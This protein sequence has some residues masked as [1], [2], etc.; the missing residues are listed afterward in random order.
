MLPTRVW[1]LADLSSKNEKGAPP[2]RLGST[3][4]THGIHGQA[5]QVP[6]AWL[7]SS[8]ARIS[9]KKIAKA[10]FSWHKNF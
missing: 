10:V 3:P 2:L 4:A 8:L 7:R 1:Q 5:G 9:H 6:T